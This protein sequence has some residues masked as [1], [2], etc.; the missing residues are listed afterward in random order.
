MYLLLP[1][2]FAIFIVLAFEKRRLAEAIVHH[3]HIAEEQAQI[4][5]K[6]RTFPD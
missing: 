6:S 4:R 1:L 2:A 3:H 5:A